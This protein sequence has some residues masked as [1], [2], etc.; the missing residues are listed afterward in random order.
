[1][2]TANTNLISTEQSSESPAE[3]QRRPDGQGAGR[4]RGRG[5]S[6]AQDFSDG[7]SRRQEG[8][9]GRRGRG[10][11]RGA[12]SSHGKVNSNTMNTSDLQARFAPQPTTTVQLEQ[13]Q[14][15]AG[16]VQGAREQLETEAEL[17]FICASSVEHYSVAPCNHRTCH[18]CTLRMRALYKTKDCAHC[19]VS[20][21]PN[22]D[23]SLACKD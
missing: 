14:E 5:H 3:S 15:V 12:N 21:I 10:S 20:P 2:A 11:S 9:G 23:P 6:R 16:Q 1:M 7:Q 13:L 19:R 22:F 8:A 18:I 4:G 17:C